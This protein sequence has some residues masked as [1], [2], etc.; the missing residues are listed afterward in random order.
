MSVAFYFRIII[1]DGVNF[2]IIGV[3]NQ[4]K[5]DYEMP[6][7]T[8][9]YDVNR[10]QKQAKIIK[11]EVRSNPT[12]L[13]SGEF[14]YGF[15]KDSKLNP[16]ITFILYAGEE[17][18]DG[19]TSLHDM[20]DFAELPESLKE[21]VSDY[22]VNIINIR[23]F[24]N[25]DV[26]KTDV[27]QVFDF[28]RYSDDM[29]KLLELV[30]NDRYY[31]EMDEEAFDVVIKYTHSKELVKAQEN[32]VEGGKNDVCKAIQDLMADSK[33]KGREEGKRS[34]VINM[35]RDHEMIEKICRYAECDEAYVEE[36]RKS[37]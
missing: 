23:E 34:L 22:K 6:L 20:I 9:Q 13:T 15:K 1:A 33:A 24:E 11:K 19:P 35:L 14:L 7:R 16:I 4:E 37:I 21:M 10:Y 28:I 2:A 5:K 26:F 8:M 32:T 31:K 25:T 29:N 18:W 27:R 36:V 3:E 17:K 30:E 12:G